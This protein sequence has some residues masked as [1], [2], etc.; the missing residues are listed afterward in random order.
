[1]SLVP[2]A[3]HMPARVSLE[4]AGT[5]HPLPRSPPASSSS[6]FASSSPGARCRQTRTGATSCGMR[7]RI[8]CVPLTCASI[9]MA[10][11]SSLE[12]LPFMGSIVV[13]TPL[14]QIQLVDFGATREY[15]KEFMVRAALVFQRPTSKLIHRPRTPGSAS[16]RP[17]P[18]ATATRACA[19]ARRSAT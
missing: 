8:R 9:F 13:L 10:C 18:R 11:A 12:V 19:G 17:P 1:M 3:C 6:A 7:G 16:C 4:R 14:P 5:D 2:Y 15:S